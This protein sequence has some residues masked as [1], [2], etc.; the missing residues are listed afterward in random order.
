MNRVSGTKISLPELKKQLKSYKTEELISIIVDCYKLSE[1]VKKYVH[2][3]LEPEGTTDRLHNEARSKILQEFYPERGEPKLRYGQA[4][5][6]ITDFNKLC[7]D[8]VK[9]V[10]LMI[11]YVELGVKF[12]NDYGDLDEPFY[13]SMVSMYFHVAKKINAQEGQGLFRL[14]KDRLEAIVTNS[15]DTGWGFY[16]AMAGIYF[17]MEH[18]YEIEG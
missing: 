3:M 7:T 1:D 8:L 13:N 9:T 16:E 2:V 18:E 11:Y 17:E 5:K 15:K 6:A 14:Y 4:K 10:D 12:T